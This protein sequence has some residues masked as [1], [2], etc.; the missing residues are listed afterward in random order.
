ML[1]LRFPGI[2]EVDEMMILDF[3]LH[4]NLEQN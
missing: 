1:Q 4:I 2:S 3:F